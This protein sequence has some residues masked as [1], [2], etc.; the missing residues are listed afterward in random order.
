[1]DHEKSSKNRS[2]V[3][4]LTGFLDIPFESKFPLHLYYSK[5]MERLYESY[6]ISSVRGEALSRAEPG[7]AAQN[8]KIAWREHFS[9]NLVHAPKLW[10]NTSK[11]KHIVLDLSY[12]PSNAP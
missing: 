8:R 10:S 2:E 11:R 12:G 9:E 5:S 6:R 1:M 7:R 4:P 3:I